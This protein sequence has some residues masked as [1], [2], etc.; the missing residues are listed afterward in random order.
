MAQG[1]TWPSDVRLLLLLLIPLNLLLR[2][3]NAC[4]LKYMRAN[5][6]RKKQ[7]IASKKPLKNGVEDTAHRSNIYSILN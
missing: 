7:S 1:T 3:C 5:K 6:K 4:G 2:L